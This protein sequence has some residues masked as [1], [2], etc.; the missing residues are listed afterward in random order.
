MRRWLNDYGGQWRN[1]V[2]LGTTS[3]LA[4]SLYQPLEAGQT[5]FVEPGL[6]IGRSNEDVYN[7]YKRIAQYFFID[8]G[9][10][11]DFGVNHGSNS[12]LPAGYCADR[13]RIEVHT[14][15]P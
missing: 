4:T 15:Q 12:Q 7:D 8:S 13:R 6:M 1:R 11:L 10:R 3:L 5:F 14:G 9:G 2:Q